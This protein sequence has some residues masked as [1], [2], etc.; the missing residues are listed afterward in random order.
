[1]P[2]APSASSPSSTE[3]G[4]GAGAPRAVAR[5]WVRIALG[6]WAAIVYAIYWLG[7]LGPQ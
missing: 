5:G 1:M 7:Y 4:E 3:A 6:A 2:P